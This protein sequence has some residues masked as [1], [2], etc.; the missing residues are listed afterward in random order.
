M[1]SLT[2]FFILLFCLLVGSFSYCQSN[3]TAIEHV[4]NPFIT[5]LDEHI[6]MYNRQ[7]PIEK[8][9]L[10][11]DKDIL[12][13]GEDI[14]YSA[15]LVIGPTHSYSLASKVLQTDLISPTNEIIV[16]QTLKISNGRGQGFMQIPKNLRTGI[17]QLRSYTNWMRNF[18]Q[19]FF[20]VKT[21]K[22][23]NSETSANLIP[24]HED[25]TDLQ[26]FPEG[27]Q[28]VDGLTSRVAFKAI[29][30]DGLGKK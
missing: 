23:L 22:I 9:Y 2:S 29:G 24:I 4:E 18:D 8:V 30:N 7:N 12:S 15:Y 27:G 25:K 28:L 17:Y 3:K 6:E 16:S 13:A 11:T 10:H 1:K 19:E 14:W 21:V 5:E 20:F 26:F